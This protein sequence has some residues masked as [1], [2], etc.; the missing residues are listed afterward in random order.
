MMMSPL[1]FLFQDQGFISWYLEADMG[2]ET[3]EL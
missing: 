2:L 3:Q 1:P